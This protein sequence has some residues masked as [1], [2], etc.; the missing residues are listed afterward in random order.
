MT[1]RRSA[2]VVVAVHRSP[3]VENPMIHDAAAARA[4]EDLP[5]NEF[6]SAP[7]KLD[8]SRIPV[9]RQD[10]GKTVTFHRESWAHWGE[11]DS[12]CCCCCWYCYSILLARSASDGAGRWED[13]AGT[14]CSTRNVPSL[15][16]GSF[17]SSFPWPHQLCCCYF[18]A[19]LALVALGRV[20]L[21]G[22]LWSP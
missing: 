21:G 1:A 14:S 17:S 18:L 20:S 13:G 9:P 4:E 11:V 8:S 19:V 2:E 3:V 16:E 12:Y 6:D 7:L 22:S 10:E 5:Q 15:Q